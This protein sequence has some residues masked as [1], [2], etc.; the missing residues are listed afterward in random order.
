MQRLKMLCYVAGLTM[1]LAGLWGLVPAATPA[2]AQGL[3]PR[4]TL[5][6][7]ATDE[8]K[9]E[10]RPTATVPG[11]LTGTVIDNAS[12]APAP[13][14]TVMI[15]E[16]AVTTD[17]NGNY[18]AYLAPGSYVVSVAAPAG[19]RVSVTLAAG[20]TTVQHLSFGVAPP[21]PPPSVAASPPPQPPA[22]LPSTGGVEQTLPLLIGGMLLLAAGAILRRRSVH[23]A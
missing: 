4:P 23:H 3:P 10:Q 9:Q 13:G 7:T 12:A 5:T 14:I 6:P 1:L 21:P 20:A 22:A 17:A 8:P 2:A 18:D 11:R 16:R 15:D 19:S